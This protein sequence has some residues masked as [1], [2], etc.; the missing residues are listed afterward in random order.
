MQSCIMHQAANKPSLHVT[1]P[2]QSLLASGGSLIRQVSLLLLVS[3]RHVRRASLLTRSVMAALLRGFFSYLIASMNQSKAC[4]YSPR[5]FSKSLCSSEATASL[6]NSTG[7]SR[8]QG[9][10]AEMTAQLAA[11]YLWTYLLLVP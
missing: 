6:T 4:V 11:H 10:Q 7:H 3:G 1:C 9:S 8:C 2:G 5:A